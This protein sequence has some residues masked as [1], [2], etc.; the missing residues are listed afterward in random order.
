MSIEGLTKIL[1]GSPTFFQAAFH[2]FSSDSIKTLPS[3]WNHLRNT[4]GTK[5]EELTDSIGFL[6]ACTIPFDQE[7]ES[8]QQEVNN[9]ESSFV[10]PEEIKSLIYSSSLQFEENKHTED[11]GIVMNDGQYENEKLDSERKENPVA[12]GKEEDKNITTNNC[13]QQLNNFCINLL[14]LSNQSGRKLYGGEFVKAAL[15]YFKI[16]KS[17]I[18]S[19]PESSW[20][21]LLSLCRQLH[22]T[23]HDCWVG[24]KKSTKMACELLVCE[25][26]KELFNV[27]KWTEVSVTNP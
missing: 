26:K 20:M 3:K 13:N 19:V 27:H 17:D 5:C 24:L 6:I 18:E 11:E 16:Y 9:Y 25:F 12:E 2:T 7:V 8:K 4:Y 1:Q 21:M 14:E 15:D 23:S 22:W 10:Q